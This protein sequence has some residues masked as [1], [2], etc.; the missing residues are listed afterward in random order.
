MKKLIALMMLS[1]LAMS[2]FSIKIELTNKI[3]FDGDLV[4]KQNSHYF[5][6]FEETLF[7]INTTDIK[8]LY[9]NNADMKSFEERRNDWINPDIDLS[10]AITYDNQQISPK[11]VLSEL[12]N[13]SE[14]EFAVYL[15][16]LKIKSN[17][18][19]VDKVIKHSWDMFWVHCAIAVIGSVTIIIAG[20]N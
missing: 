5:I 20:S 19:N 1:L 2:L 15:E 3:V 14:R 12:D 11:K 10:F 8:S 7:K 18:Q 6:K 4:G 16:E 13:M 17:N 9:V